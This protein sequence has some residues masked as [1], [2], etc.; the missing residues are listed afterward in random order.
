MASY[1]AHVFFMKEEKLKVLQNQNEVA[2]FRKEHNLGIIELMN[3]YCFATTMLLLALS[4]ILGIFVLQ[5]SGSEIQSKSF[6]FKT[7][8]F[9]T[10]ALTTFFGILIPGINHQ[11]N[12]ITHKNSFLAYSATQFR[13]YNFLATDGGTQGSK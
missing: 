3:S 13:I 8:F 1:R 9:C 2:R 7:F 11:E 4:I 6:R 12:I 5:I 10:L